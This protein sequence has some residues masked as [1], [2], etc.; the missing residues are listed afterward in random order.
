MTPRVLVLPLRIEL[1]F[2]A[3]PLEHGADGGTRTHGVEYLL[4]REVES[5][6]SDVS[7]NALCAFIV[8]PTRLE[9]QCFECL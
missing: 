7:K 3:D 4:T 2:T 8:F 1:R 5:P 9:A 6:L